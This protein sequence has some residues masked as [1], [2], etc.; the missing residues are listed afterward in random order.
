MTTSRREMEE[1]EA[2]L[3]QVQEPTLLNQLLGWF[4]RAKSGEMEMKRYDDGTKEMKIK[5]HGVKIPDGS[6]AS[7]VVDG[8]AICEVRMNR[9]YARL[10]VS[11]AQGELVP[12]VRSGSVAE[13]RYM[14][15]VLLKGIFR[16]D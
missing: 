9:G 16:P 12:D 5:L 2:D 3:Y 13:I 8:S 6:A 11:T 1:Y 4:L 15:N 14:G 10:L 7:V